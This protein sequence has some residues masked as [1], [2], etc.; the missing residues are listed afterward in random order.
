M[1]HSWWFQLLLIL[2]TINIVICSLDRLPNAWKVAFVKTPTFHLTRFQKSAGKQSF[3]SPQSVEML[4]TRYFE[5]IKKQ[6]SYCRSESVKGGV[7]IFAEKGRWTRLGAYIVHLSIILMLVGGLIG[8]LYGFDGFVNIPEGETV[9]RVRQRNIAETIPIP[10][11]IRCDDFQVSFYETGQPKEYRSTLTILENDKPVLTKDIIVNDPLRY[12]GLNLFQSS[13][14]AIPPKKVTLNFTSAESQMSYLRE[15]QFDQ[16]VEIPEGLGT[17]TLK[18]FEN[19]AHFRGHPIGQAFFGLLE[20]KDKEPLEILL[21]L[22]FASF[23][24]MRK[25][26]VIISVD[27]YEELFFTGLQ[28]TKDP[29]VPVVYSGFILIIIGCCITFFMAHQRVCIEIVQSGN[30]TM[31]Y[32]S[33]MANKGRMGM[34]EKVKKIAHDFEKLGLSESDG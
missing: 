12:K 20:I 8:S 14:G 1:Y 19:H 33:G 21:P 32:V 6:F 28:V 4:S 17:F 2:L 11:D 31:V 26:D 25:G 27:S 29:G 15:A 16:P 18:A 30:K 34:Q 10:F 24:K 7:A 5:R 3:K 9:N 13:Y 23:D 22:R